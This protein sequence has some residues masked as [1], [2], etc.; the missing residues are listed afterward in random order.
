MSAPLDLSERELRVLEA[1]IEEYVSTA[2]P[3]GSQTIAKRYRLGVSPAT[4]R[5]T[6]SELETKGY[7]YHPHTSA[8]RIP[9]DRA[10]RLYVDRLLMS[11]PGGKASTGDKHALAAELSGQRTAVE[12]LLGRAAQVLGVLTQ[13]LGVAVAPALEEVVLDKLELVQVASDRLL[14]VFHLRSGVV[15]TIFVQARAHVAPGATEQVARILNER[16]AGHTLREIRATFPARLRDAAEGPAQRELLDIF[17]EEGE[18]IFTLPAEGGAAVVLG[19]ASGLA[20]QPEFGSAPRMKELLTLTERRDV[21]RDALGR[22]RTQGLSITIG[23]EHGDPR[24]AGFTL[25]TSNYRAGPLSGVIGVLGPTRMPYDKIIGLVQ[26]TSRLV[27][28]LLE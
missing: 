27:E 26:H 8:G 3:A 10:Y 9:T 20:E 12:E 1:V 19:N 17:L 25:V 6:M 2:E 11:R 23:G 22:Q 7:L 28:G 18:E 24:L 21:L 5:S 15:R 4:I 13:E 16:L 14:L